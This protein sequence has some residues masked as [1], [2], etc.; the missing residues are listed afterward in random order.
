M[1]ILSHLPVK[2]WPAPTPTSIKLPQ[3]ANYRQ[4]KPKKK[5]IAFFILF[6]LPISLVTQQA[7]S[8][9]ATDFPS[10]VLKSTLLCPCSFQ[11]GLRFTAHSQSA[12][13]NLNIYIKRTTP[14][15]KHIPQPGIP[16]PRKHSKNPLAFHSF[17]LQTTLF[18]Q[19]TL[20]HAYG[21]RIH[22]PAKGHYS[23]ITTLQD[24][25]TSHFSI[26]IRNVS[27][28]NSCPVKLPYQ[29]PL[30]ESHQVIEPGSNWTSRYQVL[31]RIVGGDIAPRQASRYLVSINPPKPGL[32]S[33]CTGALLSKRWVVT[34]AHC[35]IDLSWVVRPAV[36]DQF[37]GNGQAIEML[38]PNEQFSIDDLSYD[39]ALI[40]LKED[41]PTRARFVRVNADP[42]FPPVGSFARALGY[43]TVQYNTSGNTRLRQVDLPLI[44][45]DTCRENYYKEE[46]DPK[47]AVSRVL[48]A[49]YID[50]GGCDSCQGDSGGPLIQFDKAG[51]VVQVGIISWG[52]QCAKPRFPGIYVRLSA[53]TEWMRSKGAVFN[54]WMPSSENNFPNSIPLGSVEPLPSMESD[55]Q[56]TPET[57]IVDDSPGSP[58]ASES[59]SFAP[60]ASNVPLTS[61]SFVAT[62]PH[63]CRHGYNNV[64]QALTTKAGFGY[65]R[66]CLRK[67]V[68]VVLQTG[69]VFLHQ[70]EAQNRAFL[71]L[72]WYRL[73][74][75]G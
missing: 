8:Q 46:G 43:G 1:S 29:T 61:V 20:R 23:I 57:N 66:R 9:A 18:R 39:I 41:A 72:Q 68:A 37:S 52:H 35:R 34:A 42:E 7:H 75:G 3:H 51:T 70:Q 5:M 28:S 12:R 11:L 64:Q 60:S 17:P 27:N 67:R 10:Q 30:P 50:S 22:I 19:S 58:V 49:G 14:S 13:S 71:L 32:S 48:C 24:N 45:V 44:S 6:L 65:I 33:G 74:T 21:P 36:V 47:F 73:S 26:L 63:G 38:I 2:S 16:Q 15:S 59:P 54:E 62:I 4:S 25:H 53:F 69:Q 56:H 55:M 31:S 40:K